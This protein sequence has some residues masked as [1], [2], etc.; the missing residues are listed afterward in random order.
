MRGVMS[1]KLTNW[2]VLWCVVSALWLGGCEREASQSDAAAGDA[3]TE[4]ADGESS[5]FDASSGPEASSDSEASRDSEAASASVPAAATADAGRAFLAENGNRAGV[6]T[7]VSGLQYEVLASGDGITPGPTDRVTTHYHGTLIDG[8]VFD[9]SMQRGQPI[10]FP[11]NGVISGWTEALQLMRVGD[12]WK[13]YIP[14]EL[15]YGKR[16]A[17][18]VIGP[19]ETL[20]F[21]VE[22]LGVRSG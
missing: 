20:I 22:L 11:V 17:G 13:L 12:R 19:D 4:V 8:R 16:G 15:A 18:G 21:E 1:G 7:T 9:S 5:G 6:V 10:E 2:M 3:A 14:P